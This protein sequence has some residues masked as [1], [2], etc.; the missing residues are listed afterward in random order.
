VEQQQENRIA[1]EELLKQKQ[2]DKV[3]EGELSE[4]NHEIYR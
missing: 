2:D 1:E 4:Q 3:A